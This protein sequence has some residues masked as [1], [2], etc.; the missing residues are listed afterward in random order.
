MYIH[1]ER[2]IHTQDKKSTQERSPSLIARCLLESRQTARRWSE[3]PQSIMN[4]NNNNN[5]DNNIMI[6][7]ITNIIII[8]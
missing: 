2:D 6:M 3:T 7:N 8:I 1:R 5:N 4:N